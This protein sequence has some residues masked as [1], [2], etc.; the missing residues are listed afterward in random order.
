MNR[1]GTMHALTHTTCIQ[2]LHEH[3]GFLFWKP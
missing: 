1:S 3:F 2:F